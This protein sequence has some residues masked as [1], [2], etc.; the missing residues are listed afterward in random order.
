MEKNH[1]FSNQNLSK[2]PITEPKKNLDASTKWPRYSKRREQTALGGFKPENNR[3]N[4]GKVPSTG[5]TRFQTNFSY[6]KRSKQR[7]DLPSG[8]L[9]LPENETLEQFEE[10]HQGTGLAPSKHELYSLFSPG[11]K[12]Q[13]LNHLLNFQC[14]ARDRDAPSRFSKTGNNRSYVK[15]VTYNKEQFLQ[16]NCQFVVRAGT[17]YTAFLESPDHLVDWERIEQIHIFSYEESQCPICL[18]PPVAAKMTKCGHVYC[19]PCI[20]HYLALSDKTWRKCPICYDAIHLP[21]LRSAVSKPFHSFTVGETVTF[22]LMRRDK[23]SMSVTSLAE[24]GTMNPPGIPPFRSNVENSTLTKLLLADT[25]EILNVISREQVELENQIVI[26]GID[27]PENIFV[28]QALQQLGIRKEMVLSGKIISIPIEQPSVESFP[29][30]PLEEV[31]DGLLN[32]AAAFSASEE[33]S[34]AENKKQDFMIDEDSNFLLSDIDIVPTAKCASSDSFYFYQAIDGQPLYLHSLNTRML[35]AMYG[36]LDRSPLKITGKIVHKDTCS[37]SED[38]RKRLKYL[39]H[40]PVC[41]SFE[42]VEI[43]FEKEVI[44]KEVLAQFKDEINARR[45][46]RQKIARAERIREKQIFEFN[47]R[48]LGKSL[49]RSAKIPIDS[50]KHFP[51][52]GSYDFSQA[53]SLSESP[54]INDMSPSLSPASACPS[55][56]KMLSTPPS[57][58]WPSLSGNRN[59]G[60]SVNAFAPLAT[61]APKLIPITGLKMMS[62]KQIKHA[63]YL[64]E[65]DEEDAEQENRTSGYG[66][67]LSIAIGA[68]LEKATLNCELNAVEEGC[69]G[70]TKGSAAQIGNSGGAKKKKHKKTL[71]FASG[72]NLY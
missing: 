24:H 41:T 47:E 57:T 70:K 68:A 43:E 12:K 22:R 72:M 60:S 42:V 3:N 45:K 61:P 32:E 35:Q 7:P 55:W 38:L 46:N 48:Q 6:D 34:L 26:D 5:K 44:S 30:Q 37:M 27:C 14:T 2:G 63:S 10:Q 28:Q 64:N 69:S 15:K 67:D 16:A 8:S 13:S 21:D 71:L 56:S 20:L 59:A 25:R 23:M 9:L 36:S 39:Q 29:Q 49:A 11:S 18:Y 62:N 17:D 66:E 51:S 50:V 52:C 1:R 33:M 65:K 54:S 40:L 53:P 58:S 4:S 19:W 31:T